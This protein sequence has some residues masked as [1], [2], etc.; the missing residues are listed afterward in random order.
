MGIAHDVALA[1]NQGKELTHNGDGY[2]TYCPAHDDNESPSL[3][4][5]DSDQS[6]GC[7]VFCHAGCGWKQVKDILHE[8]GLIEC[9]TPHNNKK[10]SVLKIPATSKNKEQNKDCFPWSAAKYTDASN[11]DLVG[12]FKTREIF[13]NKD[14]PVPPAIRWGSYKDKQ[15][16]NVTQ[17]VAAA[18]KI[19]DKFV[20]AIQRLFVE[21]DAGV[22]KKI[23]K[24][25]MGSCR[26]KGV[27]FFR[28]Q[29]MTDL[30]IGEGIET[31]LSVMQASGFN[32]VSAL[33]TAGLKAIV[34]PGGLRN[35]WI[36]VDS[37]VSFAGQATSIKFA[38]RLEK[39]RPEL[40]VELCSPCNEC[41][42]DNPTKLDFNDLSAGE[43]V[44]RMSESVKIKSLAW[45]PPKKK[46]GMDGAGE[47]SEFYTNTALTA[48]EEINAVFAVVFLQNKYRVIRETFDR[49]EK[50]HNVAFLEKSAFFD[51]YA[52]KKVPVKNGD[53][54]K[55][56]QLGKLWWEWPERR[57]H[58][59]VIF[60]PGEKYGEEYFNLFRGF[61]LKEKQGDWGLMRDHIRTIICDG[62]EDIFD[63]VIA[64]MARAVQD[65]GGKK[66]GTAL[67]LMGG[68]GTGKTFFA[69]NFGKIF[70][71]A[72]IP[73]SSEEGFLGRF[74]F[75]LARGLLIFLDEAIWGG[76]KSSEGKLKSLIT[77]KYILFEPKGIDA[78]ALPNFMNIIISSN[79]NWVVP[80]SDRERRFVVLKQ[81]DSRAQDFDYFAAIDKQMESGGLE[82][83]F[84]DLLRHDYSGINLRNAPQTKGLAS[85]YRETFDT[86]QRFW[87]DV[88]SRDSLLTDYNNSPAY[89][90]FDDDNLMHGEEA[91]LWPEN[92]FKDEI[93]AEFLRF[94][95]NDNKRFKKTSHAHFWRQTY[96]TVLGK[97]GWICS[98]QK[99]RRFI[100]LPDKQTMQESFTSLNGRVTF[101]D[102]GLDEFDGQF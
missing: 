72:Y 26:S 89:T 80:A 11:S 34:L 46:K 23:G 8:R 5:A 101:D 76:S 62:K 68:K 52:N 29:A 40:N 97:D 38:E 39:E 95:K 74:N 82:A 35:I 10:T 81:S 15:G 71:Q 4:V 2:L 96:K 20:T 63:Y 73:I 27:W 42:T 49:V 12:Y 69:E 94:C 91:G 98:K 67:V 44:V 57:E 47:T 41:F 3:S 37:D 54:T 99:D 13:F 92:V 1:L 53:S 18:T 102:E 16:N 9:H 56:V 61:P 25:M 59:E 100:N 93:F 64:W 50:K 58:S 24:K 19:G 21:K 86:V 55:L 51:Y 31:V 87:Y 14:F 66:P 83:M 90:S 60:D 6:G 17:I 85:Q 30:V 7:T 88:L 33:S 78:L 32:G 70:G 36:A 28:K 79:E 75:H 84:Y 77:D 43:I 48:L 65:P 22:I 45:R